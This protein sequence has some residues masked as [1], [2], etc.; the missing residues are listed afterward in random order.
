MQNQKNYLLLTLGHNS[1]AVFFNPVTNY[2]IGYEQ[3]RLS[4]I[5]C[6][7]QFP[8]DAINEIRRHVSSDDLHNSKIC[9]SHWFDCI[10]DRQFLFPNKYYNEFD[11][12]FLTETVSDDI[13]YCNNEFTHH[14]AHAYSA[15][16]FF[17][18]HL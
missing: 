13:T 18:Y 11:K 5:K 16:S 7:S 9:I 12:Q 17:N 4:G 2:V 15:L 1:S 8:Y 3:E 10:E 14:D 6:D